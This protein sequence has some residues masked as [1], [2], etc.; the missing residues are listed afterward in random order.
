MAKVARGRSEWIGLLAGPVLALVSFVL[1]YYL[2]PLSFGGQ[3]PLAAVPA[4]LLAIVILLIS[5]TLATHREIR[6]ASEYSD[7]A[8]QGLCVRWSLVGGFRPL[9]GGQG[10][11][12]R[13]R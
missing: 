7:R 9:G 1:A 6:Q 13:R 11:G 12:C 10:S 3:E 5:Q 4:F 8:C 2:D